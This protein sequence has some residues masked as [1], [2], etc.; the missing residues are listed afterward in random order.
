MTSHGQFE[1]L[2]YP[3]GSRWRR[4]ASSPTDP[5]PLASDARACYTGRDTESRASAVKRLRIEM[6]SLEGTD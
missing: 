4:S 5:L 1:A 2:V 3:G 6:E